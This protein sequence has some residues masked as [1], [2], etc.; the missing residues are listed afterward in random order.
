[1]ILIPAL[2]QML[3]SSSHEEFS[4]LAPANVATRKV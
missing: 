2:R 3:V 1:M 4:L